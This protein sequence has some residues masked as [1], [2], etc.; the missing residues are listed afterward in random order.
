MEFS[1]M[2]MLISG[3]AAKPYLKTRRRLTLCVSYRNIGFGCVRYK[4]LFYLNENSSI[5]SFVGIIFIFG[6][7]N[8]RQGIVV[9]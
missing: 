6:W 3:Q 9:K 5:F 2:M 4:A 7:D 1:S 8:E